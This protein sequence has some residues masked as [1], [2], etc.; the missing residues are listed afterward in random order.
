MLIIYKLRKPQTAQ[1]CIFY[2]LLVLLCEHTIELPLSCVHMLHH[3]RNIITVIEGLRENRI[4]STTMRL[5]KSLPVT[6]QKTN[7]IELFGS[8]AQDHHARHI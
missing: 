6:R 3:H 8:S 1:S 5:R 7:Y 4:C 2:V